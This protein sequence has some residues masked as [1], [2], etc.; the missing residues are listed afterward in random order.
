MIDMLATAKQFPHLSLYSPPMPS[1]SREGIWL[2]PNQ[3]DFP[4]LERRLM[5]LILPALG[6]TVRESVP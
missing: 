6:T 5:S 4:G 2:V 3:Q 1:L